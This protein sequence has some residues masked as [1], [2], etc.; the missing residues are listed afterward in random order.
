MQILQISIFILL[1]LAL[2]S[3][4]IVGIWV[5]SQYLN[6][7]NDE[8]E[9][10]KEEEIKEHPSPDSDFHPWDGHL[11]KVPNIENLNNENK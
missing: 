11:G 4:V 3:N 1:I 10:E 6:M 9:K 2:I 8:L 7:V 5:V